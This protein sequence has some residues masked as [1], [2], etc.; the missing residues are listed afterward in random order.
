MND[1]TK[2]LRVRASV[3]AIQAA[4]ATL[5]ALSLAG[6]ARAAPELEAEDLTTPANTVEVGVGGTNKAS[7]KAQEYNGIARKGSFGVFNV[8]LRGGGAYDSG[9]ATRWRFTASDLGLDKR[10][11]GFS[12]SE[13]GK[14]QINLNYDELLRQRSDTYQTPF[15]GAG[16]NRLTLPSDWQVPIVPRNSG[17]A[18]NARGLSPDVTNANA[19]ASGAS[20]APM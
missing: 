16:T 18:N 10:S 2:T 1:N 17:S 7:A 20:T 6:T 4:M 13:Q 12:V 14:F 9:D 15:L 5:A 19:I 11:V 8:D 3:L